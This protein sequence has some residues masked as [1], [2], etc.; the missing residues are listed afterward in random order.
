MRVVAR[1]IAEKKASGIPEPVSIITPG[2]QHPLYH[3]K[4]VPQSRSSSIIADLSCCHEKVQRSSVLIGDRMPLR[5][6]AAFCPSDQAGWIP[7]LSRRFEAV[8]CALR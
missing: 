5:V 7:F 6:H 3:G 2:C 1:Q 4:D 8:R